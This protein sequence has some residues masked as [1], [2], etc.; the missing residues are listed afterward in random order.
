[1]QLPCMVM[2]RAAGG[3]ARLGTDPVPARPLARPDCQRRGHSVET[4]SSP[5]LLT[6]C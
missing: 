4:R 3:L 2:H 6:G 1:M 5:R